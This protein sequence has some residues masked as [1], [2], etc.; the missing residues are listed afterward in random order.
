M[1]ENDLLLKIYIGQDINFS[2]GILYEFK[3]RLYFKENEVKII[4]S[5]IKK[6]LV[7]KVYPYTIKSI[8]SLVTTIK[9]KRKS[10]ELIR[11]ILDNDSTLLDELYTIPQKTLGFILINL[12]NDYFDLTRNELVSD[13]KEYILNNSQMFN[14]SIKFCQIL[15]KHKLAVLTKDYVSTRGGRIDEER[16]VVSDEA[17]KYLTQ[18]LRLIPLDKQEINKSVLFYTI[19][20]IAQEIL[21]IKNEDKR[22]NSYWNL[23]R[24]LPFDESIIKSQ[25]KK[26]KEEK[27]TTE[28]SE[29]D[30]EQF[31]FKILNLSRFEAKL[32]KLVHNFVSQMIEGKRKEPAIRVEKTVDP[33]RL[34]SELFAIIGNFEIGFRT[35]LINEMKATS[36]KDE[37]SWYHQ[38]KEIKLVGSPSKLETLYDKLE[39]RR[40]EDK[41]NK[42]YPEDELI[43]YADVTD[44][45]DIVLNNWKKIFAK[46]LGKIHLTKEKFEHGMNELNK[47]RRKVMHLRGIR[48]YEAKTLKLYIIPELEKIFE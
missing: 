19:Y 26:F 28:Y 10:K 1:Q 20:K 46:K 16:Y 29:I 5:L 13:W 42:I 37:K 6:K 23:L 12:D 36:K 25:I 32:D 33:F 7:E 3:D 48:P 34:H 11:K 39:F 8:R 9:G 22:R 15:Q 41:K 21:T 2:R 27:I 35:Y 38:L 18:N 43:N 4:D 47:I 44:Y 17:K 40:N 24:G 45:K 30:N 31:L 14:F